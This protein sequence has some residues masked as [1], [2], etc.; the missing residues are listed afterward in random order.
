MK[1]LG[2]MTLEGVKTRVPGPQ[3]G[4]LSRGSYLCP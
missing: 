3:R 1:A 4:K 2:Q